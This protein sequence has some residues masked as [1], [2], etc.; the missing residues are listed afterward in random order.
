MNDKQFK[1][2]ML[3]GVLFT[4]SA[5]AFLTLLTFLTEHSDFITGLF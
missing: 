4:T 3:I 2:M 1:N 5:T